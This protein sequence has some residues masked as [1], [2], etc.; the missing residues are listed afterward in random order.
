VVVQPAKR[1]GT[2]DEGICDEVVC[3]DLD[4]GKVLWRKQMPG[5][6][7]AYVANIDLT[8]A[9]STVAVAW[10]EGSVAFDMKAGKQLWKST[11]VSACTDMG[12]AGGR[13]LLALLR[14]GDESDPV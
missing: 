2:D 12:F 14:C 13:A 10:T 1:R 4:D 7:K 11:S 6:A 8:M 3:F 5:A 9:R